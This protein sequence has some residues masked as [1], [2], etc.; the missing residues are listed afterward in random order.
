MKSDVIPKDTER[1]VKL[2][3]SAIEKDNEWAKVLLGKMLLFG[4]DI[5]KDEQEGIELLQ[6][7]AEQGNEYAA[8]I[9]QNRE[10]YLKYLAT[11]SAMRLF[12][13]MGDLFSMKFNTDKSKTGF[14]IDKKQYA[15]IHEKKMAQGLRS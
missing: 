15:Q 9:L 11:M 4:I 6:S 13:Y 3:I 10:N 14:R 5:P 2:L 8:L 1:A 12:G 7:A